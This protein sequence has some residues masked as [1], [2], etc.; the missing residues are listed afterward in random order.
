MQRKPDY[1]AN[2]QHSAKAFGRRELHGEQSPPLHN[3]GGWY[4][5]GRH[6]SQAQDHDGSLYLERYWRICTYM[7][8]HSAMRIFFIIP[9]LFLNY[10]ASS[11][12]HT[13]N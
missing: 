5:A 7:T 1:R 13:L 8:R 10:H 9:Y 2:Q 3:A 12:G 6:G 11:L 4:E